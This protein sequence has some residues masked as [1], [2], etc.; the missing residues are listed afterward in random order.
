VATLLV[1]GTSP[2]REDAVLAVAYG[3]GVH[4]YHSGDYQRAYEELSSAIDGGT[5]DPRAFYFRGLSAMKLGRY[6]EAEADFALGADTETRQGGD[7]PVGRSLER[8]QGQPRLQLEKHRVRARMVAMEQ[9]RQAALR[10]YLD[11]EAAR[12]DVQRKLRPESAP[13]RPRPAVE[14]EAVGA[15]EPAAPAE[16]AAEAEPPMEKK[17]ADKPAKNA[18]DPFGDSPF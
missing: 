4:A 2:A 5:Q 10:R 14:P 11:V 17:A 12:P 9:R 6:D 3:H 13:G 15:A 18:D 8:I 7:W 1:A 16:P